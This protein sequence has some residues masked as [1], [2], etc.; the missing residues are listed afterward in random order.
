MT[1]K[2]KKWYALDN[3]ELRPV[4][5][6]EGGRNLV[7]ICSLNGEKKYVLRISALGDRTEEDYLAET[8]FV[9]YLARNGAPVT[10]VIPSVRGKLVER[11]EQ[12]GATAFVSLFEYA[13][14]M[15]LSVNGS[16][17]LFL[18]AVAM[19]FTSG[20]TWIP[21]Y[22]ALFYIVIKN[23]ENMTQI[24]LIVMSC[25]VCL[26]FT[27]GLADFIAKPY[28]ARWR[29]TNDPIIKYTIDVVKK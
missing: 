12:D 10:D 2:A 7:Y 27:Y 17:S 9:R 1:E 4:P 13:K 21:L 26:F 29:P 20:L 15:L 16:D 28:V 18:D 11:M 23:N 24:F 19:T 3:Y 22:L 8:E 14:G 25:L 6:H 5:G